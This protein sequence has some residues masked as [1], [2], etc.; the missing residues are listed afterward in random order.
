MSLMEHYIDINI[1]IPPKARSTNPRSVRNSYPFAD[2]NIGDSFLCTNKPQIELAA[3]A[4]SW[5]K[6]HPE[7]HPKF[8]TRLTPE[9]VRIWR[10]T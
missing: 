7:P 3:A 6:Y 5:A 8:V 2:M 10:T 9:G 1:P 4:R